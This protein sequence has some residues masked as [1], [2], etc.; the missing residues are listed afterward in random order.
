ML[1]C[2]FQHLGTQCLV[3]DTGLVQERMISGQPAVPSKPQLLRKCSRIS[4]SCLYKYF[5]LFMV[6]L[7]LAFVDTTMKCVD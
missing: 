3:Q 1:A 7:E 6:E 2:H 5:F 4:G